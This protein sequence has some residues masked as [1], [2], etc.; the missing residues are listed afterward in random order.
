MHDMTCLHKWDV[1]LVAA[2]SGER[3]KAI[4][5][6]V[7]CDDLLDSIFSIVNMSR[8]DRGN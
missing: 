2:D 1:Q 7:I 8:C 6:M 3:S 5:S 4:E